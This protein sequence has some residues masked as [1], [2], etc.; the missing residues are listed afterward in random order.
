MTKSSSTQRVDGI[1]KGIE[2][3]KR[4]SEIKR[5]QE[6]LKQIRDLKKD[7]FLRQ[8][9]I[10]SGILKLYEDKYRKLMVEIGT[11]NHPFP[12]ERL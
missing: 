5:I 8:L 3:Q 10:T 9:I 12:E 1:R 6:F 11:S 7:G 4:D 2:M